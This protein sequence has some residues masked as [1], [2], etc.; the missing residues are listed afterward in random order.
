MAVA[1]AGT[2]GDDGRAAPVLAAAPNAACTE[3]AQIA[4][5]AVMSVETV[6]VV[7]AKPIDFHRLV[8]HKNLYPH[9]RSASQVVAFV[10][11]VQRVPPAKMSVRT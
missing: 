2:A 1:A 5:A 10:L 8:V 7:E 3:A 9:T 11:L 6:A 4:Q